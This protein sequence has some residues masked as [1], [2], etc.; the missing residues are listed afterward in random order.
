MIKVSYLLVIKVDLHMAT[1]YRGN[2]AKRW[3]NEDVQ[4]FK[5]ERMS[6]LH[7]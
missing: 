6:K 4:Y 1:K 7:Q 3:D 5:I 2:M